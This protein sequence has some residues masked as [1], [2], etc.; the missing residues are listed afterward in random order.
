VNDTTE[1]LYGGFICPECLTPS[2]IPD[3]P[4]NCLVSVACCDIRFYY[5]IHSD[6]RIEAEDP[7]EV[8]PGDP[9]A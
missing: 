3:P 6:G 1:K 2:F 7:A 9:D 4:Y 8:K 5:F